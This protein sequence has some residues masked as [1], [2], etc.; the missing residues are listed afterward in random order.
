[1]KVFMI[2]LVLML[3]LNAMSSYAV[4]GKWK[5]ITH[6]TNNG[7]ATTEQEYL[8]LNADHTF[9]IVILV[10]LQKD[11]A[12]IK[13][14]RVEASGIWKRRDNTLVVVIKKVEVPAAKEV[15]LISQQSLENLAAN[16]QNRFKNKPIRISIIKSIDKNNLTTLNEKLKETRYIR[17]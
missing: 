10:S 13:D 15:Y 8:H 6:S 1:M 5:A 7:T 9:S 14:L 4:V 2:I 16:F 11:D 3:E 12:F 17:Q